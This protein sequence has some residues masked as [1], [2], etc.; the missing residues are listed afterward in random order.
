[1]R[2]RPR[3]LVLGLDVA[4]RT[5]GWA[6][7]FVDGRGVDPVSL[8][9]I[10]TEPGEGSRSEDNFRCAHEIALA[11]NGLLQYE[12]ARVSLVCAEAMSHP[13]GASSAARISLAWG[14]IAAVTYGIPMR[15]ASPQRIKRVVAGRVDATKRDVQDALGARFG[16]GRMDGLLAHLRRGLREHPCDA[17]AAVVALA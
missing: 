6:L 9:M 11:L 12:R 4:L 3:R 15:Q 7:A 13:P 17:L 14:A 8:G 2:V 5:L 1:M 10:A 16:R